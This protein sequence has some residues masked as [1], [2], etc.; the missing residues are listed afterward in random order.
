MFR[1]TL[2]RIKSGSGGKSRNISQWDLNGEETGNTGTNE[3][4]R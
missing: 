2:D 4:G 1:Q 3:V